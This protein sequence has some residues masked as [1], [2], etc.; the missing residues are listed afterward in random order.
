MSSAFSWQELQLLVKA[1][2]KGWC[3]VNNA[4]KIRL[5]RQPPQIN[6]VRGKQEVCNL[7]YKVD[8]PQNYGKALECIDE[9]YRLF[10][11]GEHTLKGAVAEALQRRPKEEQEAGASDWPAI[12]A[13]YRKHLQTRKNRIPDK[14]YRCNYAPYFE[15]ALDLLR[16]RNAPQNGFELIDGVL[17]AKRFSKKSGRLLGTSLKPWAEQPSSRY[18]CCLAL[19]NLLEFAFDKYGLPRCWRLGKSDYDDLLGPKHRAQRKAALSD[20]EVVDLVRAIE[21]RNKRWANVIKLY[22]AYGL[23]EWEINFVEVKKDLD[24]SDVLFVSRGKLTATQGRK[25]ENEPRFLRYLPIRDS[26]GSEQGWSFVEEWK[27]GTLELPTTREGGLKYIDGK[28]FGAFLRNQPEWQALKA[29]YEGLNGERF[30]PYALRD[31]YSA[32]CTRFG[33]HDNHAADAMG[34]SPEVHRRSYRTSRVED[35]RDAFNKA[36]LAAELG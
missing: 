31:T 36:R 7:P 22:A 15:V 21:S 13:A 34:H 9:V 29:K 32:R 4:N 12:V 35:V 20:Q 23:R 30:K 18:A 10:H 3:V 19:K 1:G 2:R 33:L 24:G 16:A 11:A 27:N 17:R 6:G 25:Q 28:S 14:T 5:G 8:E 26:E